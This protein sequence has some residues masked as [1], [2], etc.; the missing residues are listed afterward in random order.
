MVERAS[1]PSERIGVTVFAAGGVVAAMV[2]FNVGGWLFTWQESLPMLLLFVGVS[3]FS[4]VLGFNMAIS[5]ER[6]FRQRRTGAA[7]ACGYVLAVCMA[8]NAVSGHNAWTE[9]EQ[10]MFAPEARAAQ[11]EIDA[12]RAR[13]QLSIA[14]IDRQID[15]ARPPVAMDAGP[16]GR[17]EARR[18]YEMELARL[19]PMR[20]LAQQRLDAE[21]VTAS[22][23]RIAPDWLVWLVFGAIQIMTSIV[24]WAIGAGQARRKSAAGTV[25]PLPTGTA[26]TADPSLEGTAATVSPRRAIDPVI[27][28]EIEFL[29]GVR[30]EYA[31][32]WRLLKVQNRGPRSMAR[33]MRVSLSTA[34]RRVLACK[35]ALAKRD[36]AQAMSPQAVAELESRGVAVIRAA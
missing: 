30:P 13:L 27:A 8:V 1:P 31:T 24:L 11:T 6:A 7:L 19:Q 25:D 18:V 9:F 5:V 28:E 16:Q 35:K 3:L 36:A 15:A 26:G 34:Q 21:P 32:T 23:R 20:D 14:E 10:A 2:A 29:R 22:T 12:R 4:E 17:A 33:E